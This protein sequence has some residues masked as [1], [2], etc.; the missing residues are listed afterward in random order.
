MQ[1][2]KSYDQFTILDVLKIISQQFHE[3]VIGELETIKTYFDTNLGQY[4][5]YNSRKLAS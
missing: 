5:Y 3:H 2:I 4:P 1:D